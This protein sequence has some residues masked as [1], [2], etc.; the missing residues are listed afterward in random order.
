MIGKKIWAIAKVGVYDEKLGKLCLEGIKTTEGWGRTH[1]WVNYDSDR[2]RFL[3][4]GMVMT[5]TALITEYTG[6]NHKHEQIKKI[7]ITKLRN[8]TVKDYK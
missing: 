6:L 4:R 8:I 2:M 5:F 7:G 3:E 1:T